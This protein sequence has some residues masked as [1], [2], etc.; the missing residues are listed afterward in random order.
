MIK[1]IAAVAKNKVIGNDNQLPW[2]IPEEFKHFK[3]MTIGHT[4][5]MGRKTFESLPSVLPGREIIVL[6]RKVDTKLKIR[7]VTENELPKLFNSF[8]NSSNTLWIAG[9]K[10][11]YESFYQEAQELFITELREEFEGNVTLN[12]NLENY[13]KSIFKETSKFVVYIY[14]PK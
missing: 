8:R 6:T 5:L 4:L 11:V 7:Q 13:K 1:L 3:E 12:L 14:T 10:S 9:G 2:H